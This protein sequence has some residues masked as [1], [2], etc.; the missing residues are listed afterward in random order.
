[1]SDIIKKPSYSKTIWLGCIGIFF[2]A[3]SYMYAWSYLIS[4]PVASYA[5]NVGGAV[6]DPLYW[7]G[8]PLMTLS[9]RMMLVQG[10]YVLLFIVFVSLC[11]VGI[12]KRHRYKKSL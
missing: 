5:Q 2:L 1:M 4:G 11:V 6:A 9:E 10:M 12:V 8:D 7:L 3:I